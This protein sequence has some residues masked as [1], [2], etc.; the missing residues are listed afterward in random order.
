MLNASPFMTRRSPQAAF[1]QKVH[2]ESQID[3][4]ATPH[5]LVSMLF[6][7]FFDSI[8]TAKGALQSKDIE[9]KCKALGRASAIVEEGLRAALD[10]KA[11]GKVAA[12]L[13]ALYAYVATRLTYANLK[14]DVAAMEECVKLL[15]PVQ[16]AWNAIAPSPAVPN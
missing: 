14:N 4:A 1:Y 10:L 9:A 3:G 16:E 5:R 8:A 13:N 7:G 15:K 11:G 12:D 6:D 2:V